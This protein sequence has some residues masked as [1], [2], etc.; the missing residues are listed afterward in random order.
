[1]RIELYSYKS[2]LMLPNWCELRSKCCLGELFGWL[3]GYNSDG[4]LYC[5]HYLWSLCL[6]SSSR[7]VIVRLI[8]RVIRRIIELRHYFVQRKGQAF[9]LA[10]PI[11][12][13][14]YILSKYP[15][16]F[17]C[18]KQT[19]RL[20]FRLCSIV[21]LW[22]MYLAL[23]SFC[24]MYRFFRNFMTHTDLMNIQETTQRY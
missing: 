5:M 6:E 3:V 20:Y 19:I 15:Q 17:T 18:K 10:D 1:M 16:R 21:F 24:L 8:G 9:C 7:S 2:R 4:S 23:I 13:F 11:F 14:S 22:E 12:N